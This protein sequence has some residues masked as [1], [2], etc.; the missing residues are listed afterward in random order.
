MAVQGEPETLKAAGLKNGM[1]VLPESS[2]CGHSVLW[3]DQDLVV[4]DLKEDW[5]Y[6]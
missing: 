5:R 4:K 2:M 6:R 1:K 3:T